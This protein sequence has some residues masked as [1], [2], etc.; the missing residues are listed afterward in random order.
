MQ[1]IKTMEYIDYPFTTVNIYPLIKG[2]IKVGEEEFT[3]VS[4]SIPE[5]SYNA[6]TKKYDKVVETLNGQKVKNEKGEYITKKIWFS[7]LYNADKYKL[8][9]DFNE[10]GEEEKFIEL[11]LTGRKI[12]VISKEINGKQYLNLHPDMVLQFLEKN[13][14]D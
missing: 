3:R 8:F 12:Y 6:E 10:N 2:K 5:Y 13:E 7:F 11:Y 1:E 14:R 9:Y 4:F